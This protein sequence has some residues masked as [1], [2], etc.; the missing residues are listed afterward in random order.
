MIFNNNRHQK[1]FWNLEGNKIRND[2]MKD[3]DE[4]AMGRIYGHIVTLS[5]EKGKGNWFNVG[6]IK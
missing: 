3:S 1:V 2:G 4:D 5:H 6:H